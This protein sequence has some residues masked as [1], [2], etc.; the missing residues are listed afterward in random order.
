MACAPH[1]VAEAP[2]LC[3]SGLLR[4]QLRA[5]GPD[6]HPARIILAP[7]P[8]L[9]CLRVGAV[10]GS[11]GHCFRARK[12]LRNPFDAVVPKNSRLLLKSPCVL[13]D[14]KQHSA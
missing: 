12:P 8:G 7:S 13:S 10:H 5:Q 14:A 9:L 3:H 1:V 4:S 2:R 6:L 11:L